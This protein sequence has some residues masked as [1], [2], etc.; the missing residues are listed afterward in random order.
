M[1][2]TDSGK[3]WCQVET[4][5]KKEESQQVWLIVEGRE[6]WCLFLTRTIMLCTWYWVVCERRVPYWC[7]QRFVWSK[8]WCYYSKPAKN[9]MRIVAAIKGL[10]HHFLSWR[11]CNIC[12]WHFFHTGKCVQENWQP[13]IDDMHFHNFIVMHFLNYWQGPGA[14]QDVHL[15]LWHYKSISSDIFCLLPHVSLEM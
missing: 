12:Q 15:S 9:Q 13:Y 2:R 6:A 7:F 10:L 14:F 11:I 8:Q 1:D 4:K 3:Y 5:G